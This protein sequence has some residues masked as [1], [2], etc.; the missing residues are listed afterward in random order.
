MII[1]YIRLLKVVFLLFAFISAFSEASI[2]NIATQSK[3]SLLESSSI[4]LDEGD[5]TLEEIVARGLFKS[6]KKPYINIGT[7]PKTVWVKFAL[8]NNSQKPMQKTLVISS[9]MLENISLYTDSLGSALLNGRE[10]S[11]REHSTLFYRYTIDIEAKATTKYYLKV[12]SYYSPVDF[13][14]TLQDEKDYLAEDMSQQ[15]IA[16]ML[17]GV[18]MALMLYNFLISLHTRDKSYLYYSI[19]LFALVYH[20]VSYLGLTQIYLPSTFNAIDIQIPNLKGTFIIVSSSLFAMNFLKTYT[21]PTLNK[22]YKLFIS[23]S[24][25]NV[26]ISYLFDIRSMNI[27]A[28][29]AILYVAFTLISGVISYMHGNKQARL[30]IVG[31][32]L[33]FISYMML[34]LD[35]LGVTSIMQEYRSILAWSTAIDALILSLAFADRYIILQQE[36]TEVDRL[37]LNESKHREEIVQEEVT[38]KT[39]QLNQALM[40]KDI[41]L[42]EVHHRIKNNLQIILSMIRLQNDKIKDDDIAKKLTDLENRVNAISK[43][44]ELLLSS[45]NLENIDME[46]Y[47]ESLLV[48]ISATCD[49]AKCHIEIKTDINAIVPLRESIYIGLII[50]ELVTNAYKYA[51]DIGKGSITVSLIQNKNR[52]TLTIEDDGKGYIF[53]KESSTLGLQLIQT[54]VYDQLEGEMEQYTKGYTKYI[55]RFSI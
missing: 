35:A 20:Q 27:I 42:Q 26:L 34:A 25:I 14:L 31:F 45:D 24:I 7:S 23:F 11:T 29:I 6:Y 40:I 47:I 22:I 18:I 52:Y 43:T 48:D 12:K 33:L 49:S 1:K 38:K 13:G 9:P 2:I 46:T 8:H 51:F 4:Y 19:Y 3:I 44:Y 32:L 54:L 36:K 30:F 39:S 5:L 53:N 10:H 41:L 37:I 16:V 17:L 55:I 28:M 15:L 50:N 21:M